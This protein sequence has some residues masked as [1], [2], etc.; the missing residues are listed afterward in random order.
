MKEYKFHP[1]SY[2]F[3]LMSEEEFKNHKESISE[4]G[5]LVKTQLF[6]GKLLDGRNRYL[7]CKELGKEIEVEE[8]KG[9]YEQ[10]KDYVFHVNYNRRHLTHAKRV[11]AAVEYYAIDRISHSDKVKASWHSRRGNSDYVTTRQDKSKKSIEKVSDKFSVGVGYISKVTC[12]KT[13]E[14]ELY[15]KIKDGKMTIPNAYRI[16]RDKKPRPANC[17]V[18]KQ[19]SKENIEVTKELKVPHCFESEEVIHNFVKTMCAH[20]WIMEAKV[21]AQY[22]ELGE[23]E[24]RYYMHWHG[25]GF[26]AFRAA[27]PVEMRGEPSYKRAVV[28]SAKERLD[29]VKLITMAA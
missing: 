28:V 26:Q 23:I 11:C 1:L 16:Y 21:K 2:M 29:S 14:P 8:F 4:Q 13:H 18:V 10:A 25:N 24:A 17:K 20:G 22:N 6:E 9:T 7:A 15:Q 27:W 5:Q 19:N 12:L 3:S